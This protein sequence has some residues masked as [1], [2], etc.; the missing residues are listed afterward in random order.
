MHRGITGI[1]QYA[2]KDWTS[3]IFGTISHY[4]HNFH[5]FFEKKSTASIICTFWYNFAVQK[6]SFIEH[7]TNVFGPRSV[8]QANL[9][10]EIIYLSVY[11][12]IHGTWV[13]QEVT[14]DSLHKTQLMDIT[15]SVT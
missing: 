13:Q 11:C 7:A 2:L 15:S 14:Q 10:N 8:L 6:L 3:I 12:H 4:E 9:S 1:F 5:L